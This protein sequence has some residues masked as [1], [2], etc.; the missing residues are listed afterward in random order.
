MIVFTGINI[1]NPMRLTSQGQLKRQS[2]FFK[3][4]GRILKIVD[5]FGSKNNGI[6]YLADNGK[7]D[8]LYINKGTNMNMRFYTFSDVLK[9]TN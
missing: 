5:D 4:K 8:A 3:Q 7:D 6:L 2:K 9:N 1:I